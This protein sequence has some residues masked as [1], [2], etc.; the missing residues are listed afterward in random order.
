MKQRYAL[1]SV[2]I[3]LLGMLNAQE[4]FQ[5]RTDKPQGIS[6][7]RSTPDGINLHYSIQEI[8][9]ANIDNGEAKGNEIIL[10]GQFTPN[11]EGRPNLPVVSRYIAIPQGATVKLQVKENASATLTGI[12]LL[13]AAP[14]QT[15]NDRGLPQLRWDSLFYGKDANFPTENIV[16]STPTQ[17]RSLDVVLLSIT[18][19]RYNPVQRTLEVIY[20]IDID[21]RFE[22][23]NGQFGEKRYFNPDWE[24][25]LRN[26]VINGEILPSTDYY[27]YIRSVRDDD[28]SGCEYLII[29]PDDANALAWA[30]TLKAFR[31]KQGILTKVVRVSECGVNNT[32][33][34]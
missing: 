34:V 5:F 29:A 2:L 21:V 13:P 14:L 9:I 10:K 26:L 1:L 20:D 24:H 32:T 25:I 4:T 18:P 30:D 11:A 3:L 12:D 31:M 23:G 15:D 8:G 28:G 17:I 27:D 19:F 7:E 22:G 6:V 16:L 33:S